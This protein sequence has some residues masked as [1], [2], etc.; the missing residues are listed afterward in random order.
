MQTVCWPIKIGKKGK[1]SFML[2]TG[3]MWGEL[4]A[5][6]LPC[7]EWIKKLSE[8]Y[9]FT[10]NLC[11]LTLYVILHKLGSSCTS[12]HLFHIFRHLQLKLLSLIYQAWEF[13]FKLL[14]TVLYWE[15]ISLWSD[16][17]MWFVQYKR[18]LPPPHR[19]QRRWWGTHP[20]GKQPVW[21][22]TRCYKSSHSAGALYF[23]TYTIHFLFH[24]NTAVNLM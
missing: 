15:L 5:K 8:H 10:S 2:V 20:L 18:T 14:L 24:F 19:L 23:R 7:F 16:I 22:T 21:D 1:Y 6:L 4:A 13:L 3:G 17:I 11:S 12:I 9:L